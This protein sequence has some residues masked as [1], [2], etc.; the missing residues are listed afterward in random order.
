V[1]G[2][3]TGISNLHPRCQLDVCLFG[4]IVYKK[5]DGGQSASA[6]TLWSELR[7]QRAG[8]RTSFSEGFRDDQL[9]HVDLVLEELRD[10]LLCVPTRGNVWTRYQQRVKLHETM[11]RKLDELFSTLDVPVDQHLVQAR[12]DDRLNEPTV[13]SSNG[14]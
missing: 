9:R 6:Y 10:D 5:K 11:V 8:K 1:N 14:L 4:G 13:I 3:R 7:S 12:L 2:G